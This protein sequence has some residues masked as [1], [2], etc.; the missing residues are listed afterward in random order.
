MKLYIYITDMEA[1]LKGDF[2][3][4]LNTSTRDNLDDGTSWIIAGDVDF[5]LSVDREAITKAAITKLDAAIE[6]ERTESNEKLMR[7]EQRKNE[8]LAITHEP[9]K[10]QS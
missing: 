9:E 3:W 6:R 2:E 1:A 4:S 8:L 5:D 10:E 7:L